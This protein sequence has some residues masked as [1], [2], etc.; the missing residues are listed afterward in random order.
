MN[1]IGLVLLAGA[2][3][4]SSAA[5]KNNNNNHLDPYVNGPANESKTIQEVRHQ[6]V[7]LPYYGV[8]DDLGFTVNGGT[9]T[10]VGEVTQPVL[11]EDADKVV[12][13]VEGVTNVVNN[14]EVLPLSGNDDRI[15]RGVYR[16]IYADPML[17]TRYGFRALPSIHI[18]V[19]NGNVRL[20]GVVANEMD[21]NLCFLRANAVPG[22][23]HVDNELRVEG[24]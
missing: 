19:K 15:R 2:L 22:A 9:V 1:R 16:A 6:L 5:A 24:K 7:T 3:L 12:K 21:R 14:I 20:E 4:V 23:F 11:K 13:K 18:I 17:S 8:F 10:L